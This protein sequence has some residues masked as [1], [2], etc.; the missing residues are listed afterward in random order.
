LFL[1][2]EM[3]SKVFK[4]IPFNRNASIKSVLEGVTGKSIKGYSFKR[5][6]PEVMGVLVCAVILFV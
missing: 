2:K 1:K 6:F 3:D 4:D 5:I